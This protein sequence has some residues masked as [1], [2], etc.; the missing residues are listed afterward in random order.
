MTK[1]AKEKETKKVKNK[2]DTAK[3]KEKK[4]KKDKKVKKVKKESYF[5]GVRNEIAKVKWPTKK[6]VFKYTV[7]TIIFVLILVGFFVLLDLLM[8]VIKGGI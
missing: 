4:A 7:A 1:E 6:E 2:V 5:E 3:M 8:S